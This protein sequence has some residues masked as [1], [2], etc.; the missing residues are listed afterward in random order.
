MLEKNYYKPRYRLS[1]LT[2]SKIWVYKNS[3]LRHFYSIRARRLRRT[4]R[5][6]TSLVLVAQSKK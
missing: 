4:G 1:N 5:L 2:K 6:F 3:F